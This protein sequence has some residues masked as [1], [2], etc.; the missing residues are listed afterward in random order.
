MIRVNRRPRGSLGCKESW[1]LWPGWLQAE[2]QATC[3]PTLVPP[4]CLPHPGLTKLGDCRE[5]VQC[6]LTP[7]MHG[8]AF[9]NKWPEPEIPTFALGCKDNFIKK[10]PDY[11]FQAVLRK[12]HSTEKTLKGKTTHLLKCLLLPSIEKDPWAN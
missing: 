8:G 3:T 10:L 5:A 4:F 9:C 12:P 6:E 2:L 7:P 1:K 11:T